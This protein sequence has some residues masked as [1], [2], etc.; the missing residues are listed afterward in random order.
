MAYRE[1]ITRNEKFYKLLA[2]FQ[3]SSQKTTRFSK[4]FTNKFL[5]NKKTTQ[6]NSLC[7]K[8]RSLKIRKMSTFFKNYYLHCMAS[9]F[10]T[11]HVILDLIIDEQDTDS[12]KLLILN[13]LQL[14]PYY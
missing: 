12:Y 7:K 4:S 14:R 11:Q 8:Y 6:E 13:T 1:F 5:I 3:I 2:E 9:C 10:S